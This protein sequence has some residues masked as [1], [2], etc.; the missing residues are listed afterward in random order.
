MIEERERGALRREPPRDGSAD[1]PSTARDDDPR[2]DEAL[3]DGGRVG[4]RQDHG[5]AT[6][7]RPFATGSRRSC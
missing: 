1:A 3:A 6:L 4:T 7:R 2:A 5:G